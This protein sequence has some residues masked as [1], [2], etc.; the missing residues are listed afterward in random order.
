[1][2]E[3]RI[4]AAFGR[5]DVAVDPDAVF[6][7]RLFATLVQ[8][9]EWGTMPDP[10]LRGRIRR[11]L[12]L[13]PLPAGRRELRLVYMV[14]IAALL[15]P[16][17]ATALYIASRLLTPS[18]AELVRLSQQVYE[19][20]PAFSIT[21]KMPMSGDVTLAADGAGTWRVD[22]A[23]EGAGSYWL[24]DGADHLGHYDPAT[25][26]WVDG[27]SKELGILGPP[28]PLWIEYTWGTGEIT[29]SDPVRHVIPCGG[30]ASVPDGRVVLGHATDH[31][32]CPDI[33]MEYW[34]DRETRLILRMEA[35]PTT[36]HWSGTPGIA[37]AVVEATAFSVGA[38][39]AD[40]FDW[41]GPATASP[42]P[43]TIP[44]PSLPTAAGGIASDQP[45]LA[46]VPDPKAVATVGIAPHE[47]EALL[48]DPAA[49]G[50]TGSGW[51]VDPW[52]SSYL[53]DIEV[54]TFDAPTRQTCAILARLGRVVGFSKGFGSESGDDQLTE[55]VELFLE[56]DGAAAYIQWFA[57]AIASSIGD[58]RSEPLG[59]A[60]G[61]LR[62]S[63]STSSGDR[64]WLMF[65]SRSLVATLS[66]Q[67]PAGDSPPVPLSE[68][69]PA[70]AA[71]VQAGI[72]SGQPY[73]MTHLMSASLPRADLPSAFRSLAWD[74]AFGGC[75]SH[76]ELIANASN[77]D[78]VAKDIA[79]FGHEIYCLGMYS[80]S[81]EC[82]TGG[83]PTPAPGV[84]PTAGIIRVAS[85]FN[86]LAS[87]AAARGW[88]ASSMARLEE[89][90]AESRLE[91]FEVPGIPGAIGIRRHVQDGDVA[92]IDTRVVFVRGSIQGVAYVHDQTE[93]DHVPDVIAMAKALDARLTLV[94]G[95][96][97]D[98]GGSP[99]P[100]PAP[101]PSR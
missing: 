96:S 9:V 87:A 71:R 54:A 8:D 79:T 97:P 72:S 75:W 21:Y 86:V 52:F 18:P 32:V 41:V 37:A 22:T 26:V 3:E 57:A 11:A 1:M 76:D 67:G 66:F 16:L 88:M 14:A 15:L 35:G 70:F 30:A 36:P 83:C 58:V 6:A 33:D 44:S 39:P 63:A 25:L 74:A 95:I 47:L 53:D 24:W 56:E 90:A 81:G 40:L 91:H 92:E 43:S 5:L 46:Q 4:M 38:Q 68:L 84:T 28:G 50:L 23:D 17:L 10:S 85:G 19:H 29:G 73:D 2:T 78:A 59:L 94:L 51:S 12:G 60:D 31:I 61:G 101:S 93:T 82:G 48:L 80:P 55:S 69:A 98:P 7:E 20:P 49:L 62:L 34:L 13:G 99:A 100:S 65:R 42:R 27:T 64:T 77:P 45:C 89:T